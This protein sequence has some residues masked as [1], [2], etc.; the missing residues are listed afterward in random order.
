M[1]VHSVNPRDNNDV[2]L[3]DSR[4][5]RFSRIATGLEDST[6]ICNTC[7]SDG[8]DPYEHGCDHCGEEADAYY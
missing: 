8:A 3:E 4:S 5:G 2:W 7:G 1:A 6:W